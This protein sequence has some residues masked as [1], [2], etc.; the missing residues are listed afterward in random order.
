M[1]LLL[2]IIQIV[3]NLPVQILQAF[4][5]TMPINMFTQF[6]N[7]ANSSFELVNKSDYLNIKANS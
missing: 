2:F 4:N 1:I 7:L 6:N 5:E 3:H